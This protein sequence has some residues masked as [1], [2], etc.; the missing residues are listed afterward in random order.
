MLVVL[1]PVIVRALSVARVRAHFL[2]RPCAI[3]TAD[4]GAY[5]VN[6]RDGML[7]YYKVMRFDR[8]E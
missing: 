2:L 7:K 5:L 8:L 3:E 6:N 4:G 1:L